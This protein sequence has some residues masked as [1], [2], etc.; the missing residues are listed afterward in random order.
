MYKARQGDIVWLDFD[1]Q[2]GHEQ[3][4]RRPAV[5][6]SNNDFN[7]LMKTAAMVCPITNTDRNMPTQIKL[8]DKTKTNGLIMCEQTKILDISKR[9]AEFMEK[10][11]YDI[12]LEVSDIIAGFAEVEEQ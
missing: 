2:T 7:K 6:I 3:K 4:G 5:I 10:L 9:N 8:N 1:P 12:L 11:P